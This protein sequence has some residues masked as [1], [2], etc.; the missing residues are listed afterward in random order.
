M[1]EED[2]EEK[3]ITEEEVADTN[4]EEESAETK[5]EEPLRRRNSRGNR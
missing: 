5:P 2:K 4:Q 3:P 1:K